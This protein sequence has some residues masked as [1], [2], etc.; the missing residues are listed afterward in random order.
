MSRSVEVHLGGSQG[1][2]QLIEFP[3]PPPL[4]PPAEVP[5]ILFPP[6]PRASG[7]VWRASSCWTPWPPH[8]GNGSWRGWLFIAPAKCALPGHTMSRPRC[9]MLAYWNAGMCLAAL[10]GV[11]SVCLMLS[12]TVDT[13]GNL[14]FF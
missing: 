4:G 2:S 7:T 10:T 13:L 12:T 5:L 1:K 3:L 6:P 9:A 14:A 8:F 11:D